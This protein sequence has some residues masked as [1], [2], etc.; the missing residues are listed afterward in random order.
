MFNSKNYISGKAADHYNLYEKDFDILKEL[1]QNAF[2]FSIEWSRIEP[3]KGKFDQK[4]IEHYQKVVKALKER[5]IEP[6]VTLWH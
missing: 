2:R 5:N 3:K 6:F 1:G 4:E